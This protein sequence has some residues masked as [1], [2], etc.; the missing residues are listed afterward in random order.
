MILL[1]VVTLLISEFDSGLP[2]EVGF[3][4]CVAKPIT[5]SDLQSFVA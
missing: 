2:A 4:L 5:M 1:L 3:D